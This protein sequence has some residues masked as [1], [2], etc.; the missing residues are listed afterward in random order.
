MCYLRVW[1]V[2]FLFF[3]RIVGFCHVFCIFELGY[4]CRIT[5]IF[6][7]LQ[8]WNLLIN[9]LASSNCFSF[10]NI[11]QNGVDTKSNIID[12]L[13]C[14]KAHFSKF[15]SSE[16]VQLCASLWDKHLLRNYKWHVR[17]QVS[18]F[19][20]ALWNTLSSIE[21]STFLHFCYQALQCFYCFC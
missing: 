10:R 20:T 19:A 7:T 8:D 3:H 13:F 18:A 6:G 12:V 14:Q 15:R 2:S 5:G 4:T 9:I 16:N 11:F 1:A 17:L 21:T